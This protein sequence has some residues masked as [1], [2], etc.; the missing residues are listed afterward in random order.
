MQVALRRGEGG[1]RFGDHLQCQSIDAGHTLRLFE[2]ALGKDAIPELVQTVR[3]LRTEDRETA[4]MFRAGHADAALQRKDADGLLRI[5]PG[6][7]TE[8]VKDAVTLRDERLKANEHNP[9]A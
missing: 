5:V 7:T 4:L 1:T 9:L 2:K 8:A 6:G 3:Q